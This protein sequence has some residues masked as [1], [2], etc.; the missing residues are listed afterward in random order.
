L[1]VPSSVQHYNQQ[2]AIFGSYPSSSSQFLYGVPVE[3]FGQWL[4]D[5]SRQQSSSLSMHPN[6]HYPTHTS[7]MIPS[8]DFHSQQ[9]FDHSS[10][11]GH[12]DFMAMA[13]P[14]LEMDTSASKQPYPDLS[15]CQEAAT[16]ISELN[17]GATEQE[18]VATALGC[19]DG[20]ECPVKNSTVFDLMDH[21]S[22]TGQGV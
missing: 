10:L 11:F 16:V 21:F 18:D 6:T 13:E 22:N 8:Q 19:G 17:E 1:T 15:S 3:T 2:S 5:M 14:D 7:L 12:E 4:T 9:Q 20:R